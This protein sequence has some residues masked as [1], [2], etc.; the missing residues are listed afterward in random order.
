MN[1]KTR[2]ADLFPDEFLE[3]QAQKSIVYLPLGICEPHGHISTFGLDTYKADYLC[4]ESA[5]RFGGIVA[6]TL[7][8]QIHEAGYHAP[9]LAEVLGERTALMTG[10]PPHIMLHFF[11]YQLRTF[12][13][14]GFKTAI[15]IS[16]HSGGNQQDF[17]LA[18]S[19]FEEITGMRIIVF[20]DPE[21]VADEYVGDHA[22]KYEIS[23]SLYLKPESINMSAINRMNETDSLGR[24]A[25]GL[26][27]HAASAEM[28]KDIIEKSLKFIG[29]IIEKI[30]SQTSETNKML[31]YDVVEEMYKTLVNRKS[32]WC[33]LNKWADQ[34]ATPDDSIWKEYENIAL[35]SVP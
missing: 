19:I 16:G 14:A 25:Q 13:N 29:K 11:L 28:G 17:R 3:K 23:Q 18:G 5:R 8:Y 2:W 15:V 31:N 12:Y 33:T 4:D 1:Q 32:E 6:P 24:F 27:A 20:S 26:D 9:W 7:A 10:M 21:L 22:G 34:N 30:P 35:K